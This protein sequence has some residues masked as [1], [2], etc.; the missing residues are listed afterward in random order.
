LGTVLMTALDVKS[1]KIQKQKVNIIW[2][3]SVKQEFIT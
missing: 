3:Q 1:R 2:L